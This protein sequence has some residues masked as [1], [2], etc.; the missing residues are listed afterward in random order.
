MAQKPMVTVADIT[1][2]AGKEQRPGCAKDILYADDAAEASVFHVKPGSGVPA[3]LHSRVF[4]LFVGIEG[5]I[6]IFYEGQHGS[7]S[8]LLAPGAFCAMPPGVRHEVRN[9]GSTDAVFYLVH[10]PQQGYDFIPVELKSQA[11]DTAKAHR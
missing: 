5:E 8:F 6:T 7:G 4:D 11:T 1:A 10:A 3:H 2:R 9:T